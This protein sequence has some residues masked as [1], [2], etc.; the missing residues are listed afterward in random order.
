MVELLGELLEETM[1]VPPEVIKTTM[2]QTAMENAPELPSRGDEPI[3][4]YSDPDCDCGNNN[5]GNNTGGN[6]SGG[7]TGGNT[8]N[9][10]CVGCRSVYKDRMVYAHDGH[11]GRFT[12]LGVEKTDEGGVTYEGL[13]RPARTKEE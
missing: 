10:G 2:I 8:P 7:N 11:D 1:V 6:T 13:V 5:G 4:D 3:Y 12:I 9:T